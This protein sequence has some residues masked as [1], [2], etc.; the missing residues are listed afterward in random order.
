MTNTELFRNMFGDAL[1]CGARLL[2]AA[3]VGVLDIDAGHDL[4]LLV[5]Q[6]HVRPSL[7]KRERGGPS[8]KRM[9]G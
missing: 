1:D 2:Q 6:R 4:N 3:P 5:A 7:A 8:A 9:V